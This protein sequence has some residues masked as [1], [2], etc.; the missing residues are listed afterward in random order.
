M[1]RV[2]KARWIA[3]LIMG[4]YLMTILFGRSGGEFT[5]ARAAL[6]DSGVECMLSASEAENSNRT[7]NSGQQPEN[8]SRTVNLGQ[9]PELEDTGEIV[10]AVGNYILSDTEQ[11]DFG[12]T[13][14][15]ALLMEAST[16]V[17]I[18]EM[19]ADEQLSP[20]SITKIMTLILIFEALDAGR[21]KLDDPVTTSAHARSMGGSQ[22]FLEEGEV[23][24]VETM[25]KC[26]VVASANDASV[27]MAEHLAG[28]ESEF[29]RQ[30]NE[31]AAALGM[32]G[33][34]FEDCCGLTDSAN[35]YTTARDVA[36]M[37]RELITKH[38]EVKNYTMIWMENITHVTNK[39]SSEFGLANTNKL[40]KMSNSFNVTGLKTGSTSLAKYCLSATAEKDGVELIAVIMAS[41]NY[42]L[43]FSEAQTLLNY[44]Y[45]NCRLYRDDD[46]SRDP[47]PQIAVQGGVKDQIQLRYDGEFSYLMLNGED[48]SQVEKQIV[49]E[50]SLE[51]PV[52]EGQKVGSLN[53]TMY[54][55]PI[56]SVDIVAVEDVEKA[57]FW[58]YFD[59]LWKGFWLTGTVAN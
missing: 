58:H 51:A 35:H 4:M 13:A 54:G 14:K 42:K 21:I 44:G 55:K 43:R 20:A 38:P 49:L 36:I 28:S 41:E 23:Q 33:T 15:S 32:T 50:E 29:I 2:N 27:A 40:L 1:R 24:S 37:S 39:G 46:S 3:G 34:N 7:V 9:Q 30:M 31:K 22:V 53:Y 48:N 57:G 11:P 16:G 45:S 26:I 59:W 18:Y 5:V 12:I 19:N 47:L 25:I 17:V 56:G 10:E 52:K 8:S 6:V